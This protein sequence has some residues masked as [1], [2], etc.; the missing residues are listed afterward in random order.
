MPDAPPEAKPAPRP[1]KK[2]DSR[3]RRGR[4]GRDQR[5]EA[6]VGMGDDAPEF[7]IKSFDE[8]RAG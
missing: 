3:A 4:G 2:P 1:E 8:R 5:D 7:I 6:V